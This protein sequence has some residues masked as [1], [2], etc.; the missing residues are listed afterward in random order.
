M[1]VV[2]S[3][4]GLKVDNSIK[5]SNILI[6]YW[7]CDVGHDMRCCRSGFDRCLVILCFVVKYQLMLY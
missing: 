6:L 4:C 2:Y 7:S 1:S 5:M 3:E